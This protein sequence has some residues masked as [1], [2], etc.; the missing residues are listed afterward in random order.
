MLLS[1]SFPRDRMATYKIVK[2]RARKN[3]QIKSNAR[4]LS[5]NRLKEQG[6]L[7]R[8]GESNGGTEADGHRRGEKREGEEGVRKRVRERYWQ[9]WAE[10]G[11]EEFVWINNQIDYAYGYTVS[12]VENVA[13]KVKEGRE[14]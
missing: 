6:D 1:F 3:R 8:D 12:K 10:E 7:P 14:L 4:G 13:D 5:Q 2:Y 9:H 11:R